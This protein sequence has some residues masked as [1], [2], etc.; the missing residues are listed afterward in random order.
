MLQ[1]RLRGPERGAVRA[2]KIGAVAVLGAWK[3][4]SA[5]PGLAPPPGGDVPGS[6]RG[7]E[8][9]GRVCVLFPVPSVQ[10]HD[11]RLFFWVLGG[12]RLL[13]LLLWRRDILGFLFKTLESSNR[14]FFCFLL[15]SDVK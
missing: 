5:F 15:L 13:D 10:C 14:L 4:V 3:W 12:N 8:G 2:V 6:G 9:A 7:V 1:L 11:P